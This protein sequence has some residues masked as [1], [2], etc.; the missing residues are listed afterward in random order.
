MKTKIKVMIFVLI[1]IPAGILELN[2]ALRL[3]S[4]SDDLAV[5]GG[6]AILVL[7]GAAVV[8]A[9]I[10]YCRVSTIGLMLLLCGCYKIIPPGEVGIKVQQTGSDRGVSNT[11]LETGRV[12]YNPFNENVLEYP[13]NMQRAIWT[14]SESEGKK[15]NEELAFQSSDSLHFTCDVAVAYQLVRENVPRFY[16]QFRNDDLDSFTHGF[17]R[18]AVRKAIGIAATHYTQEEINGGKQAQFE[19]EAQDALVASMEPYG[20]HIAQ[21]AFTSPPRPPDVVSSAI[22]AKIAAIQRAEQIENEK[23]QAIAEG[24]K[25]IALADAQAQANA[26]I[27]ASIT[28]QLVQWESLRVMREKW[29]GRMPMVQGSSQGLMLSLPVK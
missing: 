21:L 9:A 25:T 20:V 1:A 2:L 24:Q 15:N 8:A 14:R 22:H 3:L 16:V 17:F 23:R 6:Y 5:F 11:P 29:D 4:I 19:K 28:P 7:L 12:F 26:H 18:D 10:K 27:N 13:T